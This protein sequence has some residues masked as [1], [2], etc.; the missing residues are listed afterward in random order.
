MIFVLGALAWGAVAA[1]SLVIGAVLGMI[2]KWRAGVVG[3][4]LAFGAGALISSVAFELAQEGLKIAGPLWVAVGLAVGALAFFGANA[5]VD[6]IGGR[7]G[8]GAG[9]LPLALGSLLDGIPEQAV[10]GIGLAAGDGISVALLV[11][12][13]ISNL[14]E[15][16]GSASDMRSAGKSFRSVTSL[17]IVVSVACALATLGG[18]ALASVA[19]PEVKGAIDG[20]AAGAL[21]VML[22]DSM[23]PE[24]TEKAGSRAG[25]ITVIGFAVAAALSNLA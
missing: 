14:P 22:V 16:I 21:L 25:L 17:W 19:G 4:V 20:F 1:S 9:G 3:G 5:A 18:Y 8:G 24:A 10:L 2:R 13:F 12:I 7:S 15:G 11:A 6:R 23:I